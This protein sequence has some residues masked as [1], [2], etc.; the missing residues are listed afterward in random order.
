[1]SKCMDEGRQFPSPCRDGMEGI[2]LQGTFL[3]AFNIH[4]PL[5]RVGRNCCMYSCF[6]LHRYLGR[7]WCMAWNS[8]EKKA[9][10]PWRPCTV[11]CVTCQLWPSSREP[12]ALGFLTLH[13]R[14]T[15]PDRDPSKRE[16]EK[17]PVFSSTPG[18]VDTRKEELDFSRNSRT[19][20]SCG[21]FRGQ[22]CVCNGANQREE[23]GEVCTSSWV[24][25]ISESVNESNPNFVIVVPRALKGTSSEKKKKSPCSEKIKKFLVHW[26][27]FTWLTS[28]LT[29][30]PGVRV[31]SH[32]STVRLDKGCWGK[33]PLTFRFS[34]SLHWSQQ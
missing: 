2:N 20:P 7:V 32:M 6:I 25:W 27:S 34:H 30:L 22:L 10:G 15:S 21:A 4:P 18:K 8:E 29:F 3:W 11:L 14:S 16:Q 33:V 23:K 28:L 9:D 12:S 13:V 24:C 26:I 5:L 17:F 19:F 1:M 31:C